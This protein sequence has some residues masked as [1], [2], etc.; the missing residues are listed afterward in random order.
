MLRGENLFDAEEVAF[1]LIVVGS[2]N[3]ACGFLSECLEHIPKDEDYK[4]LVLEQV[5]ITNE[6]VSKNVR[7]YLPDEWNE[8]LEV[9][10]RISIRPLIF[11]LLS[12]NDSDL[13]FCGTFFKLH[14][15]SL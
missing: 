12:I 1:D 14:R 7:Y 4:I 10:T 11:A 5:F 6:C 15:L 13:S 2:G 3:G 8:W 9:G